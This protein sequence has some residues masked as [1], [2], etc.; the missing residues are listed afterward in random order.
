[1][2]GSVL[3]GVGVAA[4]PRSRGPLVPG[5][6]C[7]T[8][9]I[10]CVDIAGRKAWLIE[11]GQV[12]RGPVLAIPGDRADPTPRGT[13]RVEWKAERYTSREYLVQMPYA[14]FFAPGGIAFH[15]GDQHSNSAG[16]VKL[17][18]EDAVAFF[19]HLQID[20]E[21]QLR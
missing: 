11:D 21:V 13:F 10:A 18:H 14:V 2:A 16:C 8:S 3:A 6:P 12:V 15:E 20:D 17:G 4:E 9:A 7:T 5:T 19:R 1:M